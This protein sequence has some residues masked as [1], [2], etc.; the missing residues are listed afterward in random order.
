MLDSIA[1]KTIITLEDN[2]LLGGFG[3]SVAAYYCNTEKKVYPFAYQ[4]RFIP[5]G[6]VAALMK[7]NGVD[8]EEIRSLIVDCSEQNE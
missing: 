6:S 2:M 1:A 5:Q 3:E 7:E 4:D 8:E